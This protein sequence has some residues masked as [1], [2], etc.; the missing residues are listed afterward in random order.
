MAWEV[1]LGV[2]SWQSEIL[3]D[4]TSPLD[5]RESGPGSRSEGSRDIFLMPSLS[6]EMGVSMLYQEE[7]QGWGGQKLQSGAVRSVKASVGGLGYFLAPEVFGSSL[8]LCLLHSYIN[9]S[10]GHLL[11]TFP[12]APTHTHS[13]PATRSF[14]VSPEDAMFV[15]TSGTLLP[16]IFSR[17]NGTWWL[18]PP[19]EGLAQQ[20]SISSEMPSLTTSLEAVPPSPSLSV[21][22]PDFISF[23]Q[24]SPP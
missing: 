20:S 22:S 7:R 2:C 3:G 21:P 18:L 4:E 9:N 1:P 10:R 13:I 11:S 12:P 8:N 19:P 24:S 15:P 16:G 14:S 17:Q 23:H 5:R 6:R